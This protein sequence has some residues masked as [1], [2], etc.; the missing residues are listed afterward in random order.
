MITKILNSRINIILFVL[1]I[2]AFYKANFLPEFLL[3]AQN[4]RVLSIL[5]F[6]SIIPF[7]G[8]AG[9]IKMNDK[10]SKFINIMLVLLFLFALINCVVCYFYRH[11]N[12]IKT[13]TH[14][15]PIFM[16]YLYYPFRKLKMSIDDWEKVLYV[17]FLIV[18]VINI[19]MNLF[20]KSYLFTMTSGLDK[21]VIDLRVRVFGD[22]IL[23]LGNIICLNKILLRK[24]VLKNG[25]LYI[26]SLILI[27]LTGFRMLDFACVVIFIFMLYKFNKLDIRF[28]FSSILFLILLYG[29][30]QTSLIKSRIDE[31]IERNKT[32]NFEKDDYIRVMLLNYY[33]TDYFKN[34]IEF[35]F[36]SGMVQR[37]ITAGSYSQNAKAKDYESQYSKE[38]SYMSDQF[39]FHPVDMGLIGLSWEAGIPAVIVLFVLLFYLI[40]TKTDSR[41]YYISAWALFL[42]IICWNNPKMYHH[43]NMIYFTIILVVFDKVK[44]L[45]HKA[46]LLKSVQTQLD[47]K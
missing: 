42:L 9:K 30:T 23:I 19:I 46:E 14:W 33:Y 32:D 1:F 25:C 39:H 35:I 2:L 26:L 38:V 44:T 11:Q 5:L 15:S 7:L 10:T 16:I 31:M 21:F 29:V 22:G 20:P 12:V 40:K 41:Y 6:I 28:L 34:N 4:D 27:F 37:V 43:H 13:L 45:R 18:V 17:L 36:G 8:E 47:D 24:D 3:S